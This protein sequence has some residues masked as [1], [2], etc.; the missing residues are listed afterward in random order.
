MF[1]FAEPLPVASVPGALHALGLEC[2]AGVRP[3]A[4]S[5]STCPPAEAWR[6]LFAAA[7]AGGA[8]SS[9]SRGAYGR[10][11]ARKSVTALADVGRDTVE[12]R[13]AAYRRFTFDAPTSPW[14]DRIA[15]DVALAALTPDGRRLAVLAATDTD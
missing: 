3:A 7:S 4:F 15:R 11:A 9:G 14:F 5:V 13:A 8:Y 10:L 6:I 1:A 12:S 2:L